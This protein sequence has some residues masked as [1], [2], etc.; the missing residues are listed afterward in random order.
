KPVHIAISAVEH[1]AGLHAAERLVQL[2]GRQTVIP[3]DG[4]GVAE[5]DFIEELIRQDRPDLI[6]VM[7]VNNEVGVVQPVGEIARFC[8]EHGIL[9]HCDAVQ[10]VGNGYTELLQK[11][12][13]DFLTCT[14]HKYGG[15]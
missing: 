15:P 4:N 6:S 2:G 13:I 8:R 5:L 3:V 11:G 12:G 14:A 9:Y 7:A 1:K 10:A